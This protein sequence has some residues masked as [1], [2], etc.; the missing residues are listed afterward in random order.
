M[1]ITNMGLNK[2]GLPNI[3]FKRKYR[4]TFELQAC[5]GKKIPEYFV[6]VAARPHLT[7]EETEIN[8]LNAKSW[9][10]GK[11]AWDTIEITYYDISST[12]GDN[13]QALWSWIAGIYNFVGANPTYKQA[14]KRAD[15]AGSGTLRMY[16]G[17]GS[18]LE[19]WQLGNAFP[20]D[21]NWGDLDYSNNDLCDITLTLRYS[22][23]SYI[24]YCGGTPSPCSCTSC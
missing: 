7:I 14:T 17:C 10:P 4:W 13:N 1:A 2:L 16:D 15:W 5:N 22:E 18:V 8:F 3:V 11:A 12:N 6:K 19:M 20:V 9:I 23:V 24:N 21:V